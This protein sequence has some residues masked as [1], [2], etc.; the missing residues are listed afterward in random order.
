MRNTAISGVIVIL[1]FAGMVYSVWCLLDS[2]RIL[3]KVV[4][5]GK[6]VLYQNSAAYSALP[7]EDNGL[8]VQLVVFDEPTLRDNLHPNDEL[9]I[10]FPI[11]GMKSS[12][13]AT[14]V[15]VNRS[16][17]SEKE[18][19]QAFLLHIIPEKPSTME[20]INKIVSQKTYTRMEIS[21]RTKKL[22]QAAME[23][24]AL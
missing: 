17:L 20:T 3:Y 6:I 19:A 1:L 21:F 2:N 22:W 9:K 24:M 8:L 10:V 13:R 23:K 15:D 18:N 7:G 11:L 5:V 4:T 14:L 12:L 16:E